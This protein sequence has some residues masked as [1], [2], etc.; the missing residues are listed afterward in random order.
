[1]NFRFRSIFIFN[2]KGPNLL[3]CHFQTKHSVWVFD[4]TNRTNGFSSFQSYQEVL[5]YLFQWLAKSCTLF[6]KYSYNRNY[7]FELT[8]YKL[9]LTRNVTGWYSLFL[10]RAFFFYENKFCSF[11]INLF[12]ILSTK[13][14]DD[15]IFPNKARERFN[16]AKIFL[17]VRVRL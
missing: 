7:I 2:E 5:M 15:G 3:I 9:P 8:Y 11:T 6:W 10:S 14:V 13:Q 16:L 17:N 1:M 12:S 4:V